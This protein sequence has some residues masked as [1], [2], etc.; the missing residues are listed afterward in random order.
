MAVAS[1][2]LETR[3]PKLDGDGA[4]TRAAIV[5][6]ELQ[7]VLWILLCLFARG[8]FLLRRGGK[9]GGRE[10]GRGELRGAVEVPCHVGG[11]VR[12]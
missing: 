3:R 11:R 2:G 6:G 9:E 12:I 1:G 10:G 7:G 5:E 4:R 8:G